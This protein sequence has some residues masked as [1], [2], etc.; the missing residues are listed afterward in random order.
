M[1]ITAKSVAIAL[2]LALAATAAPASA[3]QAGQRIKFAPGAAATTLKGKI[4]GKGGRTYLLTTRSGQTLQTL[5][6]RSNRS[7]YFNVFE[8]DSDTA[9]HIGSTAG[10]EFGR[11]QTVAGDYRIQVYLMRSAARRGESCRFSLS[12]ELRDAPGG[13]SAGI[14]DIQMQ[15]RCKGEAATMY[16]VQPRQISVRS[17]R[18]TPTGHAID[19]TADKGAEGIKKLRCLFNADRTFSHIMAMT[20]DGE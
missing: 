13:S 5:F 6:S 8:P 11:S 10:N 1:S 18:K 4:T 20:P 7:C 19:G 2:A 14:S 15:D 12:I 3:Q 9:V 17:V 16:G